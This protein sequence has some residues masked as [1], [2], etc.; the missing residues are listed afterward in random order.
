MLIYIIVAVTAFVILIM[1][2]ITSHRAER[3]LIWSAQDSWTKYAFLVNRYLV[4]V[5]IGAAFLPLCGFIGLTFSK[6]VCLYYFQSPAPTQ[7][8]L[9]VVHVVRYVHLFHWYMLHGCFKFHSSHSGGECMRLSS[10]EC[11]R[12]G[13]ESS[14]SARAEDRVHHG[15]QC[16]HSLRYIS[17]DAHGCRSSFLCVLHFT[18]SA[19]MSE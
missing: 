19:V 14:L 13:T 18:I 3:R 4:P 15:S 16:L 12:F 9:P 7:L 1:D 10:C 5:C 2:I 17:C 6:H 11:L 8:P